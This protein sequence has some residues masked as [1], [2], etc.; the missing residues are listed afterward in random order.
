MEGSG[1]GVGVLC[2]LGSALV[3]AL[4]SFVARTLAPVMNSVSI[5]A[6]RST[7]AGALL[8]LWVAVTDGPGALLAMSTA[9]LVLLAVSICLAIVVGDNLFFEAC[10]TIGIARSLTI[11]TVYPLVSTVLAV[12]LLGEALTTAA[13]VGAMVTL[14]GLVLI[15]SARAPQGEGGEG[16]PHWRY[17]LGAAALAAFAWGVSPILM[18][19]P[20][21]EIDPTTAQA[22]RLPI[23]SALLWATPWSRGAIG[24]L[25]EGGPLA[26]TRMAALSLLTAASAVL[27]MASIKYAGVA[28]ATVAS[29]TAPMF[30][31]PI[32]YFFLGERQT[33]LAL[34]G[35]ALTVVGIAILQA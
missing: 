27:Y 20:L 34:A 4:I 19:A 31:I 17:G 15:V 26:L 9:T 28:V 33:P 24:R 16:E 13:V 7:V 8:V 32:G 22:V 3:W 25:R 23:A 21:Q 5:N 2:A 10:R 1:P 11:S 29:A 30:A 18:K 35:T 14:A 12:L 6:V